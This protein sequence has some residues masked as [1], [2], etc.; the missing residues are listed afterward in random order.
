[1]KHR[2][3][4]IAICFA[5]LAAALAACGLRMMSLARML[6]VMFTRP[7]EKLLPEEK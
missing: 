7:A 1:M 6:L 5:M 2:I 4:A 3:I